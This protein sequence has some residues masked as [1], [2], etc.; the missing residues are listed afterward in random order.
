MLTFIIKIPYL[1]SQSLHTFLQI[2]EILDIFCFYALRRLCEF[3]SE[4][5]ILTRKMGNAV[6]SSL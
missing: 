6:S 3:M 1:C 4:K 2:I 5:L